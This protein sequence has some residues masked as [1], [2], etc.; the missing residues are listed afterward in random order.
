[1]PLIG[2]FVTIEN[3]TNHDDDKYSYW[4]QVLPEISEHSPRGTIQKINVIR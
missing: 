1:M 3:D 2:D 4:D